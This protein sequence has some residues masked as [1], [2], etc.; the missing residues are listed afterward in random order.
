MQRLR[1]LFCAALLLHACT[2][3]SDSAPAALDSTSDTQTHDTS[4]DV[5]DVP[6]PD[7]ASAPDLPVAQTCEGEPLVFPD[8]GPG[9]VFL[10]GGSFAYVAGTEA[11]VQ[12]SVTAGGTAYPEPGI[13]PLV[14]AWDDEGA[15]PKAVFAAFETN[16]TLFGCDSSYLAVDGTVTVHE[17]TPGGRFR[18]SMTNVQLVEAMREEDYNPQPVPNGERLCLTSFAID[19]AAPAANP[20]APSPPEPTCVTE[21]NGQLVG[22]N[23]A[24]VTWTN[25][26]GEPV[27]LHATCGEPGA[28]ELFATTGWC[29]ACEV[30]LADMVEEHGGTLS[31][32]RVGEQRPG[33]DLLILLGETQ[34]GAPPT[35]DYC[36]AYAE[37][38][39]IDPTMVVID[40]SDPPTN[41]PAIEPEG[42]SYDAVAFGTVWSVMNPFFHMPAP[43]QPG[44]G[45]PWR[46][47][48]NR[49]NMAYAWSDM[50]DGRTAEDVYDALL[51]P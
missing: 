24:D 51:P 23:I 3:T 39:N 33:R 12:I 32:Q 7:A 41:V 4:P 46:A 40:S 19:E 36:L 30:W 31:R 15:A 47:I 8:P 50:F 38:K 37:A 6:S 45:V 28:L 1:V 13:Y 20:V 44:Y 11:L 48:L 26:L 17:Y 21:G 10:L 2:A 29:Q 25:C 34:Y 14:T 16:C 49:S 35:Q 42:W 18:L 22:H 9:Q 5:A 43:D 27:A